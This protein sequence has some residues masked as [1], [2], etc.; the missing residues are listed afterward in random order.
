M[1]PLPRRSLAAVEGGMSNTYQKL[2][3]P[4]NIGRFLDSQRF[5]T[6]PAVG[7]RLRHETNGI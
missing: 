5:F 4:R 2:K 1:E 6:L 3:F 7:I